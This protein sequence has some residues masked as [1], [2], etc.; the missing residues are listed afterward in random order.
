MAIS[1]S[2]QPTIGEILTNRV[3]DGGAQIA[4]VRTFVVSAI[5]DGILPTDRFFVR[6][7]SLVDGATSSVLG[8]V[9]AD[10]IT[11][12][13]IHLAKG[14]EFRAAE[15]MAC[16]EAVLPLNARIE[17]AVD[18]AEMDDIYE[19]ERRLLYLACTRASDRLMV[20]GVEP[21]SEYL[22]DMLAG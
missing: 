13:I 22:T 3:V 9:G 12:N 6:T 14:L 7:P 18:D 17:D 20:S 15:V 19:I 8:L 4:A 21:I 16:D 10:D 1:A 11:I 5:T 2:D